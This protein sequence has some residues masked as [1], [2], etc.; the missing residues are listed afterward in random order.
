MKKIA[1][2]GAGNI[3][4]ALGSVL[5]KNNHKVEFWDKDS[6][7]VKDQRD[8]SEVVSGADFVFLCVPSWSIRDVSVEISNYIKVSTI[9]ISLAKGIEKDTQKTM[10]VVLSESLPDGHQ[11]AICVGPMMAEEILAGIFS[12]GVIVTPSDNVFKKINSLF[13]GSNLSFE[14]I[15]DFKGALLCSVLKN[16]YVMGVGILDGLK[17]GDNTKGWFVSDTI[18]E[19]SDIID[20]LGGDKDTVY[21]LAGLGDLITTGFSI[22]S[23]NRK[24]GYKVA[25]GEL[26][27]LDSEG[28]VSLKLIM[29]I[30]GD[31]FEKF[32]IIKKI[33]DIIYN[34]KD[35]MSL[36]KM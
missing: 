10:D 33:N 32:P 12:V 18:K 21:G 31:D 5:K 22:H 14:H 2:I 11:F 6:S 29:K 36:L 15:E 34:E 35:P 4:N 25:S 20:I 26:C 19:M 3:G 9:I 13:E 17:M 28:A 8:L 7:K 16:I 1:I 24:V 30:L 23:R 27:S